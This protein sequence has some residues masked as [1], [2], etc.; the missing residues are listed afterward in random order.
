MD[1][2]KRN[3][4]QKRYQHTKDRLSFVMPKG[5]KDRITRAAV[6]IGVSSGEFVRQ[7]IEEK[8]QGLEE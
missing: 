3:E 4:R 5:T 1:K 2:T 8:L 6:K 7:A